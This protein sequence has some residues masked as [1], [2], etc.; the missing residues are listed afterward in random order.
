MTIW[1]IVLAAGSGSRLAQATKT[2]KQFILWQKKPLYWHSIQTMA[3]CAYL[4]GICLVL[5]SSNFSDETKALKEAHLDLGLP[6]IT[7]QG[8]ALRQDSV[9]LGLKALPLEVSHVLIHDAARPFASTA[10]SCR[11]CEKLLEGSEAVIPA[12]P[13][14]DTIKICQHNQVQQTLERDQLFSIQTPQGFR[15][16]LL[17]QGHDHLLTQNLLV[18][19]D[20]QIMEIL[21]YPVTIIEGEDT[22]QKITRPSDLKLL[23]EPRS[24]STIICGQGYDVHRYGGN[25]PLILGGV[26]I[27]SDLQIVA[28]S[29]GDV[30]LHALMDALLGAAGLGDIGQHFPDQDKQFENISSAVLLDQVITLLNEKKIQPIH[31]D[32]TIIAQKPKIAPFRD[33]IRSNMARLLTLSKEHVN[34]KATTEELLGFTGRCE[35]IKAQ[36]IV[37]CRYQ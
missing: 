11:I 18:T 29:D 1:G 23:E 30:L 36:C 12:L 5:P 4:S 16:D 17:Q 7:C 14:T 26:P 19:D 9:R 8:G 27:P 24:A 34:I 33:L 15:K 35:G 28:H 13:V 37:T 32:A 2:L 21:G 3:K 22:N 10:L 25:R 20:A 6:L 31:V